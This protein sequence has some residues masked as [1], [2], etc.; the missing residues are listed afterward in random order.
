VKWVTHSSAKPTTRDS[1]RLI[2]GNKEIAVDYWSPLTRGRQIFG[3][4]VP[5][6]RIW[7]TG[8]NNAT[9]IRSELT[10][11]NDGQTL[12]AGEYSLWTYPTEKG[13]WLIINK[14]ANVWGTEYDSTADLLRMPLHVEEISGKVE[15]FKIDLL[16]PTSSIIRIQIAWDHYKAWAD[17]SFRTGTL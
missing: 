10:L 2:I 14:K 4:V 1:A 7:R 5:W 16:R 3:S 15:A 12:P 11:Q 8:A 9:K 17:F 6:N 13:W